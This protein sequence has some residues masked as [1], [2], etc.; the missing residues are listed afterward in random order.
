M[1]VTVK[2]YTVTNNGTIDIT[3]TGGTITQGDTSSPILQGSN[4]F[5]SSGTAVLSVTLSDKGLAINNPSTAGVANLEINA[6]VS[7]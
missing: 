5:F 7:S 1:A 2:S 3:W 6:T 4:T